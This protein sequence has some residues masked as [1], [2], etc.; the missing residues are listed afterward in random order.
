ME[1]P[2]KTTPK[3][4]MEDNSNNINLLGQGGSDTPGPGADSGSIV[5]A[6]AASLARRQDLFVLSLAESGFGLGIAAEPYRIPPGDPKWMGDRE[7]SVAIVWSGGDGSRRSP[8]LRKLGDGRGFIVAEWG[9]TI[10]AGVYFSP[11]WGLQRVEASLWDLATWVRKFPGRRI[12]L[13]GDFNAHSTLWGS[14]RTDVR[15]RALSDWI[16]A[17]GLVVLNQGSRSTLVRWQGE[18]IVDLT[19]ATPA[20]ARV[21]SGWRVAEEFETLSDHLYIEMVVGLG[22]P[23]AADRGGPR[24]S[25][26]WSLARLDEDRLM[27]AAMV[28]AWPQRP[29]EPGSVDDEA[30]WFGAAMD[31][32]CDVA[33]P[34]ATPPRRRAAY[35]WTEE[36]AELRRSAVRARREF[37]RARRRRADCVDRAWET[38]RLSRSLLSRAIRRSKEGAWT[39]L[40]RSLDDDP[41]GRPYLLVR[42]KLR[43]WAPPVT[44]SMDPAL[45]ETVLGTL[46]PDGEEDA[47]A[48]NAP[49]WLREW[50]ITE[51]E[52]GDALGALR[53]KKTA[54]GP[55]GVPARVWA[56]TSAIFADRLRALYEACLKSGVFPR[57]WKEARLVLLK[58]DGRAADQPSAYRPIC[59]LDEVGKTF[60]R[61]LVGRLVRHLS[62]GDGPGLSEDQYGFREGRSTVEANDRVRSLLDD[63]LGRGGVALGVSLDISN[64]FNS[65]PWGAIGASLARLEVPVYLQAVVRGYLSDR[66]LLVSG[67]DGRDS[68][69]AVRCGV[70]QG[71]VLGP[72]LWNAAYDAVLGVGLPAGCS[73]VCYADDT[74]VV[75]GGETWE[76]A[77]R[78]AERA[79]ASVV[80]SVEG[81]GLG[82]AAAKT[83]A[84]F[85]HKRGPPPRGLTLSI[86]GEVVPVGPELKYLGLTLD[87]KWTFR[88]HF[89]RLA[90]RLEQVA[91][92][93]SR[94]QPNL[95]GPAARVRRLYHGVVCSI[96]LYGAPIWASRAAADRLIQSRLRAFE[97][98]SAARVARGYHT[99]SHGAA[100]VLAGV[101]PI[102]CVARAR[103]E[104]Y[105]RMRGIRIERGNAPLEAPVR[106]AVQ[107]Q[108][109]QLAAEEW[110]RRLLL[111]A[112]GDRAV[113]AIRPILPRWL[114]RSWGGLTY[115]LTQ[116]LTG[117]GSFGRYL[118]RI[119]KERT[120]ECHHCGHP[121]D[122]A[123]HTLAECPAFGVQRGV[124]IGVIGA[125]LSLPAVVSEMVGRREAWAAAVTFCEAVMLQKETAERERRGEDGPARRRAR[126]RR[127]P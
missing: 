103:A 53:G 64:A 123:Q 88:T 6:V 91:R 58:K 101:T 83:E 45:L 25:K 31:A 87:P 14:R 57:R 73:V 96:A 55:D 65:L 12:L 44:S 42:K 40:L 24:S 125:D 48:P 66:W 43:A 85:F 8:P 86:G 37:V 29:R 75:A 41:W 100:T 121:E 59:L 23:P 35:W 62:W 80:R 81:L 119:G 94:L 92:S 117:H 13:A 39:E 102:V 82:V 122:T 21:V 71:S 49:A 79:V 106:T 67:A 9:T 32:V 51:E 115:R 72:C 76:D 52:M 74:L 34:R 5:P 77:A 98:R 28:V 68:R 113:D 112:P 93:L 109:R 69:R 10:I 120:T 46:F 20:A 90:P 97:Q 33:M 78:S 27:A 4:N 19:L 11:S 7:E 114:G 54:P 15:G 95:G 104:L 38:Y 70:P 47:G 124:L 60:E 50:G 118:C 110:Q 107:R 22:D 63:M 56:L 36:I 26:R 30:D 3:I 2:F 18:S 127:P 84:V 61:I 105:R 17:L 16:A 116:V 89:E 99:I 126:R 1:T 111:A 108:C